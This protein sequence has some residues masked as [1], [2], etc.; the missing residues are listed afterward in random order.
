MTVEE[1]IKLNSQKVRGNSD[2]MAFYIESFEKQFGKKPN[3]AGCTFK[4]DFQKLKRAIES[5]SKPQKQIIMDANTEITFQ[6][7]SKKGK[8]LSFKKGKAKIYNYDNKMTE[9]FAVGYLTHGTKAEIEERKKL[10][11]VL[12][13]EILEKEAKKT[14]AKKSGKAKQAQKSETSATEETQSENQ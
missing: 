4:T 12:P 7:N 8:I 1:L 2:L 13:K 9:E 3:C 11:K 10:F 14:T 6:L 5:K